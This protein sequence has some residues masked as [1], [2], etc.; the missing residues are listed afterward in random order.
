MRRSAFGSV[1]ARGRVF[2]SVA[3]SMLLVCGVCGWGPY[4]FVLCLSF[5]CMIVILDDV[6]VFAWPSSCSFVSR[7]KT[8]TGHVF[9]ISPQKSYD[10]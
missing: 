8:T 2:A 3:S 7:L 6:C 10:S 9:Y 1:V 4:R 5:V